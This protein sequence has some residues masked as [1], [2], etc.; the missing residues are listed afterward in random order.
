MIKIQT[1]VYLFIAATLTVIF[2]M[3]Y[4]SVMVKNKQCVPGEFGP[5]DKQTGLRT[6]IGEDC[7]L[8]TTEKCDVDCEMQDWEKCKNGVQKR[9]IKI[10]S[11]NKG[12]KCPH[13]EQGCI[14]PFITE[15]QAKL[16]DKNSSICNK[17]G[18]HSISSKGNGA[19]IYECA[20]DF[21][22]SPFT[23]L[24]TKSQKL[25]KDYKIDI[26]CGNNGYLSNLQMEN[27]TDFNYNCINSKENL[28][29]KQRETPIMNK[30]KNFTFKCDNNEVISKIKT[31][32]LGDGVRKYVYDCCKKIFT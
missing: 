21:S 5:C 6:R 14:L 27:K 11:K 8:E 17:K 23:N 13:F 28:S 32:L 18:I 12:K 31:E 10:S 30:S 16:K 3:Y 4:D 24:E 26:S 25:D 20:S 1:I 9:K 7:G 29:C 22:P 2:K 19:Y 15:K